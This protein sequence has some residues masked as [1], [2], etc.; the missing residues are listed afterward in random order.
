M[1]EKVVTMIAIN[2]VFMSTNEQFSQNNAV[3]NPA[4]IIINHHTAKGS[5]ILAM[6]PGWKWNKKQSILFRF[7][8]SI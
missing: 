1:Y 3:P 6:K 7:I 5:T 8:K 2:L 4:V